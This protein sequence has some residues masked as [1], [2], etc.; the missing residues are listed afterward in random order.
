MGNSDIARAIVSAY[1]RLYLYFYRRRDPRGFRPSP[2]AIAVMEHLRATGP[3]TVSE[4]SLHLDRSQSAVSELLNRLV[5]RGLLD[6]IPD[7]RDRRRTLVWL[8][9]Q[10]NALLEEEH[11]VLDIDRLE[12]VLG[13][14]T[15]VQR[16]HLTEGLRAL[17]DAAGRAAGGRTLPNK[18]RENERHP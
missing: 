13:S 7:E 6:R 10:G 17:I 2:E 15:P 12:R 16:E 4:A 14:M 1:S 18:E 11:Q 8:S 5:K 9:K 3:L